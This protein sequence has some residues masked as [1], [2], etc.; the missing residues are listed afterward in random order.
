[1]RDIVKRQAHPPHGVAGD[2]AEPGR[3]AGST[4]RPDRQ[5]RDEAVQ[6]RAD[7]TTRPFRQAGTSEAFVDAKGCGQLVLAR[8]SCREIKDAQVCRTLVGHVPYLGVQEG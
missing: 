5:N 6:A 3:T 2:C 4:N 8:G 7:E 1:M